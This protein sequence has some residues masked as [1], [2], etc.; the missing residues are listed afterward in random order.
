MSRDF[1]LSFL[2]EFS[3][4]EP[5]PFPPVAK[6]GVRPVCRC[7]VAER[8]ACRVG[9]RSWSPTWTNTAAFPSLPLPLLPRPL[10]ASSVPYLPSLVH[11]HG[12]L[13]LCVKLPCHKMA[14]R[15][16][17]ACPPPT[18]IVL[19]HSTR[20]RF[21]S[22][23]CDDITARLP[24]K[25]GPQ[26][27]RLTSEQVL[28]EEMAAQVEV[29]AGDGT[30]A[31]GVGGRLHLSPLAD[32]S[33]KSPTEAPSGTQGPLILAPEPSKPVPGPKPRLTPKPFAVEK[34]PSIRPIPA[35]K[36]HAR[37]RPEPTRPTSYKPDP[38][39]T[40]NPLRQSPRMPARRGR[41]PPPRNTPPL[42]P[43]NLPP[44]PPHRSAPQTCTSALA[45]GAC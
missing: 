43:S 33:N 17:A 25:P 41:C 10:S 44:S 26:C 30:R 32:S 22:A 3:E 38:P 24:Q 39:S 1:S 40:L 2:W 11:S 34:N 23:L 18:L 37:P 29:K 20:P 45:R 14:V 15:A 7:T 5:E 9:P 8:S 21:L 27:E 6:R 12:T 19:C 36:P 42:H 13:A 16:E 28:I 4:R 35:P 31:G